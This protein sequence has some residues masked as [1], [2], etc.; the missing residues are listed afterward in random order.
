MTMTDGLLPGGRG[1]D[2]VEREGYFDQFLTVLHHNLTRVRLRG[3][4]Y[5]GVMRVISAPAAEARPTA[6]TG[7]RSSCPLRQE[8][9]GPYQSHLFLPL[10]RQQLRRKTTPRK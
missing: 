7:E 5:L 3:I 6:R 9:V 10:C 8:V 2:G 4:E 1:V